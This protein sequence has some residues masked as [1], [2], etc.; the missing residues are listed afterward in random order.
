LKI[1]NCQK[2][3]EKQETFDNL[4]SSGKKLLNTVKYGFN[5]ARS[6]LIKILENQTIDE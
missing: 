6:I 1:P 3:S 4:K 5:K 2:L